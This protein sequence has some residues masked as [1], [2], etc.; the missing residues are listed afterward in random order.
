[1]K[2]A[3]SRE[4]GPF[5]IFR[6]AYPDRLNVCALF[7]QARL[8]RF[9]AWLAGE[10]AQVGDS[11][12]SPLLFDSPYKPHRSPYSQVSFFRY[13]DSHKTAQGAVAASQLA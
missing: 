3:K 11:G 13:L 1:M 12:L 8:A 5:S 7:R 9:C 4:A 6:L 10:G 2:G